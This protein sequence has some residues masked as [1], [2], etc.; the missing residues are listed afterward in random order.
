M[1]DTTWNINDKSLSKFDTDG[2]IKTIELIGGYTKPAW[3]VNDK[4]KNSLV[5]SSW[6]VKLNILSL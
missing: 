5:N 6:E 2:G 1:A 3:N 4:T